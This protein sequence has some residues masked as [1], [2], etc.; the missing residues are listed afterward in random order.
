MKS[1]S[2][3]SLIELVVVIVLLAVLSVTAAPRFLNVQDDARVSTFR[4]LKASFS[5]AVTL[6]NSKWLVDGEPNPNIKEG[7]E[8]NWGY[9]IYDLHFNKYGY[10]RLISGTQECQDILENLLPD[11]NLTR[12]DYEVKESSESKGS[13]DENSA[14]GNICIYKFNSAP[15]SLIYHELDGRV[16]LIERDTI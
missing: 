15:F 7:R 16:E 3:F 12:D 6:F 13:S 4:S 5:T 11:S 10:P 8:G 1:Q 14:S 9:K 2:G